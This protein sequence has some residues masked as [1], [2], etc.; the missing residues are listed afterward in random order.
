M[1]V[2]YL[3]KHLQDG[4]EIPWGIV[5]ELDIYKYKRDKRA[6]NTLNKVLGTSYLA[7]FRKVFEVKNGQWS[8]KALSLDTD[9]VYIVT[10]DFR[11]L[12][13]NNSEWFTITSVEAHKYDR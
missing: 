11:V 2:S 3:E 9:N 5:D 12:K 4:G 6:L 8:A 13:F 10:S 7:V 1:N